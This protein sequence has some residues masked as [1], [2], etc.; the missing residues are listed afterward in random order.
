[1]TLQKTRTQQLLLASEQRVGEMPICGRRLKKLFL[2]QQLPE[3]GT[4][5]YLLHRLSH[6]ENQGNVFAK[7]HYLY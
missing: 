6:M 7:L 4:N 5:Y 2:K 3:R 1:M